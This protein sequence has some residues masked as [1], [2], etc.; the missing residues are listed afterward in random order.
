MKKISLQ[1]LL[2][3]SLLIPACSANPPAGPKTPQAL[4][5]TAVSSALFQVIKPDGSQA[6]VT[7]ADLKTLPLKQVTAEG[8]V[9]EGPGLLDVL[10]F[11]G[12]TEF[13][14]VALMGTS[15]P[16][17]LTR[18]QVDDN[19]ILDFTNHGTVKLATTYV[20]KDSWTKDVA[21]ITVK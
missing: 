4:Q 18:A 8:R 11:V 16:V 6:G 9:E 7:I 3:L 19:T 1:L 14:E 13:T 12:V 17:T 5:P 15:S 20:P 21:E 10:N 2:V